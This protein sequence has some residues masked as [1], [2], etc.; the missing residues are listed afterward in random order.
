MSAKSNTTFVTATKT[1]T[2]ALAVTF[3]IAKLV[4]IKITPQEPVLTLMNANKA[5]TSVLLRSVATT[6]LGLIYALE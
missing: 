1:V 3:A 2:T 5:H 6:L 4:F